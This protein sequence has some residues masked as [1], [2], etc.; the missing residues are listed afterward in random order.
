[1]TVLTNC[2]SETPD[3]GCLRVANSLV[4]R[5]KK[6][7]DGVTVISYERKSC[8]TDVFVRSNKF[9]LTREM[10]AAVRKCDDDIL[11]IPF[12][13]R[14]SATA[15]RILI[16]SFF[17]RKKVRVLLS[18]VTEISFAAKI[19][20]LL[21]NAEFFV[22]SEDTKQKME[23][24]VNKKRIRK[25]CLGIDTE[26]FIP[27][28]DEKAT[29]LKKKYG[30][31][32]D[33]PVVLHVG[34]LNEGRNISQLIKLADRFFVLLVTST[35]TKNEQDEELRKKLL[36]CPAV[37]LIDDYIPDI[38]EIYQL[39]DVYFFPV[40]EE[41]RCIDVPLSCLEAASCNKP[42]VTTD[43]GEMKSFNGK[44]GFHFIDSFNADVINRLVSEAV[45][46]K[47]PGSRL[48]VLDYDWNAA[49][50]NFID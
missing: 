26:K 42:I 43:F 11:Y 4:S 17:A 5:I 48:A 34:H 14:S 49:I 45:N 32:C 29:E 16:L 6:A 38:E 30:I 20:L 25:I 41:G 47:N 50:K 8:L 39:S 19:F 31:P 21:C 15:L 9:L 46:C 12:P 1:M 40:V 28:S 7:F 24:T 44:N 2:L 18:Q 23:K 3:E 35:L 33:K 13:A 36:S 37:R 10:I 22:I 27:V